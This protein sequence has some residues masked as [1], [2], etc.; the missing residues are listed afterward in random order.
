MRRGRLTTL[1][2]TAYWVAVCVLLCGGLTKGHDWG[3]DFATCILQARS[4]LDGSPSRFVELNRF[5]IEASTWVIG[6]IAAPWGVPVLLSVPYAL[7]GLDVTDVPGGGSPERRTLHGRR[8]VRLLP[9]TLVVILPIN[10][11][12]GAPVSDREFQELLA[13]WGRRHWVR[14]V[15]GSLGLLVLLRA[16][17][18]HG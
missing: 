6:P 11:Q 5:T 9:F 14:S 2:W 16:A 18:H 1:G 4:I 15:W 10:K 12:L 13:R 17:L 8:P 7:F 3:D